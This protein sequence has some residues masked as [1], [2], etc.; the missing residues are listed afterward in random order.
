M[1]FGVLLR[2]RL[3]ERSPILVVRIAERAGLDIET[4]SRANLGRTLAEAVR[5]C[6]SCPNRG[7]CQRWLASGEA[8]G[9]DLFCPNAARIVAATNKR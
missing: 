9:Y 6:L 7:A 5:T 2:D 3:L 4:F 8:S 1:A